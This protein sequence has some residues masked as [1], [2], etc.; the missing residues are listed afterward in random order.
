MGS[1]GAGCPMIVDMGPGYGDQAFW[2]GH[3]HARSTRN[4]GATADCRNAPGMTTHDV[5]NY[6]TWEGTYK[7]T[8]GDGGDSFI[9]K[10]I[11]K[12][13]WILLVDNDIIEAYRNPD[14]GVHNDL[15]ETPSA[16][17]GGP[18]AGQ[19]KGRPTVPG[20]FVISGGNLKNT[21]NGGQFTK[22]GGHLRGEGAYGGS[23]SLVDPVGAGGMVVH[24]V[25]IG[26]E[27]GFSGAGQTALNISDFPF[28][29]A[30]CKGCG[31]CSVK[32]TPFWF[33]SVRMDRDPDTGTSLGNVGFNAN[34]GGIEKMIIVDPS[35]MVGESG[36]P[37]KMKGQHDSINSCGGAGWMDGGT[38]NQVCCPNG[39]VN[40]GGQKFN[41]DDSVASPVYC[42][43]NMEAALADGHVE[44]PFVRYRDAGWA[45]APPT[46]GN[47]GGSPPP[48][49]PPPPSG[50]VDTDADGLMDSEEA[51]LGTNPNNPDTDGEGLSDGAEVNAGTNPLAADTDGD[52]ATDLAELQSG[53]NPLVADNNGGGGGSPPPPPP[54]PAADPDPVVT[55]LALKNADTDQSIFDPWLGQ[56]IDTSV[57]PRVAVVA[58]T[59]G[60]TESVSFA[61]DGSVVRTENSAPFAMFDSGPGSYE[62]WTLP[63]AGAHTLSVTAFSENNAQGTASTPL[64]L[65]FQ[66]V[67]PP[68][69]AAPQPLGQPGKPTVVIP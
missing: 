44:P 56:S 17:H 1:E 10:P 20:W 9:A 35:H 40:P 21:I 45:S 63:P 23:C 54:P 19:I 16:P 55:H 65:D 27:P 67:A 66:V 14:S 15:M 30:K 51:A 64:I 26:N 2:T 53:T 32:K 3:G 7:K 38:G 52:G 22:W 43:R 29:G 39:R 69:P 34:S 13:G 18:P 5:C 50:D 68:P 61:V 62:P 37:F 24:D 4:G 47:T 49:P 57:H 6:A 8:T 28:P 36:W 59:D 11:H 42:Y 41:A 33:I 48:P 31:N 46:G 60:S 25:T 12:V 58:V